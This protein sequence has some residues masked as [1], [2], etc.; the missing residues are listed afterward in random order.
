MH[1][2]VAIA[3][4]EPVYDPVEQMSTKFFHFE[5]LYAIGVTCNIGQE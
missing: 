3:L 4:S 2:M 1:P 5:R